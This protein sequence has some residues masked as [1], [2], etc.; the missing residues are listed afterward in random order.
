[1]NNKFKIGD[2]VAD[3]TDGARKSPS[4]YGMIIDV[5][6]SNSYFVDWFVDES[7]KNQYSEYMYQSELVKVT[8]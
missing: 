5:R 6:N 8:S 3:I 7:V 4:L 1:M 2:I